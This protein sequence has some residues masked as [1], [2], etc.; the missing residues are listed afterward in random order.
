MAANWPAGRPNLAV[1]LLL[2]TGYYCPNSLF[3][4]AIGKVTITWGF[5]RLLQRLNHVRSL[6]LFSMIIKRWSK[7]ELFR[8]IFKIFTTL[9][10]HNPL[11]CENW[12]EK[13]HTFWL[14][15]SEFSRIFFLWLHFHLRKLVWKI[16]YILTK[17]LQNFS[18]FSRFFFYDYPS[19][20]ENWCE[21][22][23][24]FWLKLSEFSRIFFLWLHFHL[25][26]LVWKIAYILTKNL[27][28]FSEFSRFFFYDYPS[29]CG[30]WCEKLHT[31]WL[32]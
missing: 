22:L 10:A 8:R 11:I 29:T 12:C 27:Q 18:E 28:N 31:F 9:I 3:L 5:C 21:K 17:N 2:L 4:H 24:T 7:A 15:L 26:K 13:L 23:H 16:A 30:N 6:V 1:H 25:R 19:T 14:K 32:N 20:C